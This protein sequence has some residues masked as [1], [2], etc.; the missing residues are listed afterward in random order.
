MKEKKN[1]KESVQ[2]A[3]RLNQ[4]RGS[5]CFS[6][7]SS[8]L[9]YSVSQSASEC[10]LVVNVAATSA[11]QHCSWAVLVTYIGAGKN[12]IT[13]AAVVFCFAGRA[14]TSSSNAKVKGKKMI[15]VVNVRRKK[16]FCL[17][18]ILELV[19]IFSLSVGAVERTKNSVERGLKN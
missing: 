11:S 9:L 6:C 14:G 4:I 15:R 2:H 7:S 13:T 17:R 5:E 10:C 18:Q 1:E 16:Y 12:L 19:F 3:H 8:P